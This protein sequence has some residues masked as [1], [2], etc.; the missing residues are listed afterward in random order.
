M[1]FQIGGDAAQAMTMLERALTIAEPRGFYRIFVD[2]GPPM[3]HL[4]YEALSQEISP[5]YVQWLL[6]AFPIKE[7][8]KAA[9]TK[10]QVDQ[11]GL[12][13]PLSDRET[14]PLFAAQ[15]FLSP[16]PKIPPWIPR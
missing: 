4:L 13:D 9:S 2:E 16:K 7:P 11:S 6:V 15:F 14:E 10:P 1:A 3:A 8:E 12:I 5:E